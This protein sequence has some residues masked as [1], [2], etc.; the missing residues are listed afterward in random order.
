MILLLIV[1]FILASCGNRAKTNSAVEEISTPVVEETATATETIEESQPSPIVN[2]NN[3]K[4]ED[5]NDDRQ[6]DD[7]SAE[8]N[9]LLNDYERYIDSYVSCLKKASNGD[10]TAMTEYMTLLEKAQSM[11]EKIEKISNNLT[12]A[13]SQRYLKLNQKLLNAAS[14]F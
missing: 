2:V 5:I 8:W 10:M 3:V 11:T 6:E 9:A 4:V 1:T 7:S 14:N 12:P 13:Q